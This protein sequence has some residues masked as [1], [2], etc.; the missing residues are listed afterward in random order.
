MLALTIRAR[1]AMGQGV[2]VRVGTGWAARLALRRLRLGGMGLM[3]D[4]DLA[5]GMP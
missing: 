4:A 1:G 5:D 2:R 3:S